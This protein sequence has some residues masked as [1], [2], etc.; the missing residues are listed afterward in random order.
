MLLHYQICMCISGHSK[1]NMDW[2]L[3]SHNHF[4]ITFLIIMFIFYWDYATLNFLSK[5]QDLCT[6]LPIPN[7]TTPLTKVKISYYPPKDCGVNA[8]S[9]IF[10]TE[11]H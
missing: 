5:L 6:P 3:F 2:D 4:Y 1:F 8:M 11:K 7:K 9:C 10:N